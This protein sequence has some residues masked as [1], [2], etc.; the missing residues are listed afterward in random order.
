MERRS[1]MANTTYKAPAKKDGAGGAYTWGSPLDS[2]T[3]YESSVTAVPSITV[4]AP[5][6]LQPT[7]PIQSMP[8]NLQDSV[9]FPSL[10][11]TPT[12]VLA[13]SWG[14]AT[15]TSAPM[16]TSSIGSGTFISSPPIN[17]GAVTKSVSAPLQP[18]LESTSP[19][20]YSSL[21]PASMP[22]RIPLV[23]SQVL[24]SGVRLLN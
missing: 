12:P 10:G 23:T 17:V 16:V 2:N 1:R 22:A 15:F 24:G 13:S 7:N 6:F 11:S 19:L 9:A 20:S 5:S 14:P 3:F 8:V 18:I 21:S 4:A